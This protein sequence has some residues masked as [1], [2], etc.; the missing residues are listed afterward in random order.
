VSAYSLVG[1]TVKDPELFQKYIEGHAE[2]LTKFGGKFL[3]AG[4]DFECIEGVTP[5]EVIVVHEWPDRAA[6]HAWYDSDDYRPW[7]EIRFASAAANVVLID[8]LPVS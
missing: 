7:K 1:V 3:A 5:G 4:S 8:A 2:S 6:F